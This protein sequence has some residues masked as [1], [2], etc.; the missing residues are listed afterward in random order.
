MAP[1]CL[2]VLSVAFAGW[3]LP[4]TAPAGTLAHGLRA[5]CKAG[6]VGVTINGTAVCLRAGE[7]CTIRYQREYAK[8]RFTCSSGRLVKKAKATETTTPP[9]VP[10]PTTADAAGPFAGTW[11][12]IDPTDGSHEQATFGTDGSLTF[13]DDAATTCGGV[14]AYAMASGAA[15]GN[16]WTAAER[17]TLLC[18]DNGGSVPNHLFQFTLN[19]NGTLTATGT[20]DVWTREPPW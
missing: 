16:V 17:T 19:G 2:Y 6:S 9:P 10:V 11:Y 1:R 20:P 18:P 8:Y 3:M 12:A 5:A 14:W 7:R 13:R 15:N 4:A